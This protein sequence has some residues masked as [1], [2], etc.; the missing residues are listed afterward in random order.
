MQNHWRYSNKVYELKLKL[1][2]C[3][4]PDQD[5]NST[6]KICLNSYPEHVLWW[7]NNSS[8]TCVK[9]RLNSYC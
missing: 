2:V 5:G 1:V 3:H 4:F 8:I 7:H 6:V 9:I